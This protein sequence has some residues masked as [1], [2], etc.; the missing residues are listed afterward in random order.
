[1]ARRARRIRRPDDG[2]RGM[3]LG[4]VAAQVPASR[5]I[6]PVVQ[7]RPADGR[8]ER[9]RLPLDDRQRLR[10]RQGARC[11]QHLGALQPRRHAAHNPLRAAR[12]RKLA[13]LA[14]HRPSRCARHRTRRASSTGRST[15]HTRPARGVLPL[16][17]RRTR[18]S[19]GLGTALGRARRP[20]RPTQRRNPKRPRRLPGPNSVDRR[21]RVVR[22]RW[23][24]VDAAARTV[25]RLC[26]RSTD[27]RRRLVPLALQGRAPHPPR[28]LCRR[29]RTDV[30]R[31]R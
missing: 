26:R 24:G 7:L 31:C 27:R 17:G 5:R 4:G 3:G 28:A 30:D 9:R 20:G 15:N 1:M 21:R 10:T 12:R 6:P 19:R 13:H 11:C 18:P 16:P 14:G 8:V 2:R 25:R 29:R 23:A 22:L